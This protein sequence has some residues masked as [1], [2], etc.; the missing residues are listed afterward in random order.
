[1]PFL[2][3]DPGAPAARQRTRPLGLTVVLDQTFVGGAELV[4]LNLLRRMDRAIVVPRMIC[5]RAAGP[6]AESFREAGVRVEVLD[7]R[8]RRDLSTVPKLVRRLRA[9]PTDVV[10]VTHHNRAALTLGRLT[11][12]LAGVP[13]NVVAVHAMDVAQ[14]GG[15]VLPRHDVNTLFLSDALVLLA[16]SQGRYLH[17][18]EGV[19]RF[20]WR[21]TRE[22]VVPNGIEL[23]PV[24]GPAARAAARA[25]LGLADSDLVLGIVARLSPEKAHEVLLR[26]FAT[27]AAGRPQ[28]RLVMVGGGERE[29]AL[30]AEVAA[31][32]LDERVRFAGVRSDVPELLAGFD[33]SCLSSMHEGAPLTVLE[34][35]AVGLPVMSTDC[36]ALRDM[37]ADGHE[38]FLVPVGD[39]A[40]FA[41]R[42]ARLADDPQLR[43]RMGRQARE[44]AEREYSI[45]RTVDGYQR[46]LIELTSR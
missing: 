31:L 25:R 14:V 10:L 29:A 18:Q 26:A 33:V 17:D 7:R 1:M 15:R 4:L 19:G 35:M 38:G 36:G 27:V 21:R 41:E 28:L 30:R 42:L 12:R 46:L 20:W 6:L 37:V 3:P 44:R 5:L 2:P 22:V 8:G 23:G 43:A 13:A 16:P 9:V 39:H 24:P 11:A 32:G 40:A 34:A 45:D